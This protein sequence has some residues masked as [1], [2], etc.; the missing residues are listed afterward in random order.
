ME[1][2]EAWR[3]RID[4][5]V[6]D[7]SD[8]QLIEEYLKRCLPQADQCSYSLNKAF[9]LELIDRVERGYLMKVL[10]NKPECLKILQQKLDGFQ[11]TEYFVQDVYLLGL[12][13]GTKQGENR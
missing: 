13:K 7:M 2:K 11:F 5:T 9:A 4:R 8:E 3:L 6:N 12:S 10:F 1:D